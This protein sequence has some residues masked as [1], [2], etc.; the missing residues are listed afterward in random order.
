MSTVVRHRRPRPNKRSQARG[1]H[2][3]PPG[4]PPL[5]PLDRRIDGRLDE[6][7]DA[8]T[9]RSS[10]AILLAGFAVLMAAIAGVTVLVIGGEDSPGE[11]PV[12][13]ASAGTTMPGMDMGAASGATASAAATVPAAAAKDV[14]FEPFQR[15]DPT[16][17]P[18]PPGP[19]KHFRVEVYQ[20]VTKVSPDEPPTEVWSFAVN[21]TFYRGTG[22]S[23]PMV[24]NVGDKVKMT[25][26]TAARRRW[27]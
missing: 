8:E 22:V 27:A 18:V 3:P 20:H 24:V 2:R 19:V 16:L 4:S 5:D 6:R 9:T 10:F 21:G 7:F 15:V 26:S 17:P 12:A 14:A 1:H 25:L 23:A 13:A 11:T